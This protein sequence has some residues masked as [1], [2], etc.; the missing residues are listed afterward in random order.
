MPIIGD[1]QEPPDVPNIVQT[2]VYDPVRLREALDYI[3]SMFYMDRDGA[4]KF[5]DG[6]DPQSVL[7]AVNAALSQ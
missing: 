1:P 3:G 2:D 6:F 7:I 5:K 4:I